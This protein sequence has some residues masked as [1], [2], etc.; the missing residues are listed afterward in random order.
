[1]KEEKTNPSFPI[2]EDNP[3]SVIEDFLSYTK[4]LSLIKKR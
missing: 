2:P 3:K 4:K 1:M